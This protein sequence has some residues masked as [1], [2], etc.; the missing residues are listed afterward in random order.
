[1]PATAAFPS[2]PP[3]ASI[4]AMLLRLPALLLFALLATPASADL[5]AKPDF[6]AEGDWTLS[7]T[8]P[9]GEGPHPLV[10]FLPGCEGWG[11]WER[12]SFA[13]HGAILAGAGWGIAA[14]DVLGPRGIDSICTDNA[15]L[16]GL[17]DEAAAAASA[18]A[19][20]RAADP[21]IEGSRI[22][23]MG[24]SFGGSVALDLASPQR[25]KLAGI[26][27]TFAAVVAYYPWCYDT[28]G[29]GKK[30]DFD[31]PVLVL[32]G[33]ADEWTPVGRCRSLAE[34]QAARGD[35]PPFEVEVYDGA[36]HS[37][38]LDEMP[39]YDI[40]GVTGTQVVA[41]NPEAA[42]A[43]RERYRAWL[44]EILP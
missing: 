1:M 18:A 40:E 8:L 23:F 42:A 17:R 24:Q 37:F 15:N 41:G 7:L 14:L 11:P 44:S 39:R 25:R 4:A 10:V 19:A 21:R 12:Q 35:A 38:D 36:Y 20:E 33:A 43:S 32:G 2:V 34:A 27:P 5:L 6:A 22:V 29:M 16:E 28:Y 9:E 31:L 30:A 3:D 13:R 26:G